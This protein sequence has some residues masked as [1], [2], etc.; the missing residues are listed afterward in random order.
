MTRK[1]ILSAAEKCVCTSRNEEYGSAE[2]N[3]ARIAA[4]WSLYIGH[5][6][7]ARDVAIMM[8][9]L[10]LTRIQTGK[11]HADNW[12][13]ACGYLACGAEIEGRRPDGNQAAV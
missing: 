2:D 12:I 7:T 9:M 13:D 6:I 11:P 5:E 8:C 1:E 3:F 10:K 4:Y